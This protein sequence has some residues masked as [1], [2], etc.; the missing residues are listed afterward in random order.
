MG[1][2]SSAPPPSSRSQY[3][4]LVFSSKQPDRKSSS[5]WI[6][7]FDPHNNTWSFVTSIPGLPENQVLKNFAITSI[8]DSI[9]IIGGVLCR[10]DADPAVPDS[11]IEVRRDVLRYNVRSN[12]WSTC[13]SL[14]LP[15]Y[16]F[17]CT[18][19]NNKIYV[20]GGQYELAS[21]R[22]T[23]SVEAY[24]PAAEEWTN[25][26]DMM[27][28]RYKCVGVTWQGKVHVVGGFVEVCDVEQPMACVGRCSA[29]VYDEAGERW[30]LVQG[31]WQLDVP[32]NQIVDVDGRLFSSGDC[33]NAWKGHVEVYDGKLSF[34]N[35]VENSELKSFIGGGGGVG[36]ENRRRLYVTMAA[37][38][39]YLY[40]LAG[41]GV[42]GDGISGT[43]STVHRFDTIAKEDV[44]TSFDPLREEG[45]RE[46]C[47]HCCVVTHS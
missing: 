13:A 34:W 39:S 33:L 15:R 17:A 31:M 25:L 12:Q 42:G 21:A 27:R 14:N 29:E 6:S 44:W 37:I 38:G 2:L 43:V 30:G 9:Y 22:G 35:V 28:R 8:G 7:R 16:N 24:D 26:P 36:E 41:Y 32:P 4:Y 18:V 1:S 40:F 11:E 3:I 10:R 23:S 45:E 46:M 20:A 5:N 47:S 19:C